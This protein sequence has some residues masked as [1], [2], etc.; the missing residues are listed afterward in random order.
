MNYVSVDVL[1]HAASVA[2][3]VEGKGERVPCDWRP[4]PGTPPCGNRAEYLVADAS[5]A[6]GGET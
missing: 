1:R 6:T 3:A 4:D 2:E 5:R